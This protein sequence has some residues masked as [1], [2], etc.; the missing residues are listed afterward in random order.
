MLLVKQS[1]GCLHRE[2]C[3]YTTYVNKSR[4]GLMSSA[5]TYPE[6]IYIVSVSSRQTS[7]LFLDQSPFPHLLSNWPHD[8]L[9][10]WL[11]VIIRRLYLNKLDSL[12][13]G[14]GVVLCKLPHLPTGYSCILCTKSLKQIYL[15]L[16]CVLSNPQT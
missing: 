2:P 4:T 16:V 12:P 10:L 6:H 13:P 7:P 14:G 5:V 11:S 15:P 1:P 3:I 9:N 8:S